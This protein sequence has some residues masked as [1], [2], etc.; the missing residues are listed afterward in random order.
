MRHSPA[1]LRAVFDY[2]PGELRRKGGNRPCGWL[3]ADGY[4]AV[5]LDGKTYLVHRVAWAMQTGEW[6]SE[7]ID[8]IDGRKAQNQWSNL[9]EADRAQNAANTP[10]RSG[11]KTGVK[12][13]H[14]DRKTQSYRAQI[15]VNM[16][17]MNLG[18]FRKLADAAAAYAEAATKYHGEYA[19]T[20]Q[21]RY[22]GETRQQTRQFSFSHRRTNAQFRANVL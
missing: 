1:E 6:P 15:S 10:L 14:Y 2:A 21:V 17:K 7:E 16:K 5:Q 4:R 11:N 19:N 3:R 12:G 8:H 22:I 13:V 9:R 18:N 20:A